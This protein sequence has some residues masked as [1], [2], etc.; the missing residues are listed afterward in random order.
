MSNKNDPGNESFI[1]TFT[2][3]WYFSRAI[4]RTGVPF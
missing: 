4:S 2:D 1:I 3:L